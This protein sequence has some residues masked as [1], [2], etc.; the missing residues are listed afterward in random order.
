MALENNY[1][2][3]PTAELERLEYPNLYVRETVDDYTHKTKHSYGFVTNK[4]TRP[5]IISALIKVVRDDITLIN[6][7]TTL[8]EMQTFVRNEDFRPEAED[9]AHDDCVMAL[10]IAHYIRPNQRYTVIL[11]MAKTEWTESMWEDY[12]NA[13]PGEREYLRER[14]G[15]PN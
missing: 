2:T 4:K 1:S 7:K 5:V 13:S 14:W 6:D 3:Y 12:R 9:G 11:P 8:E 15:E 10:A